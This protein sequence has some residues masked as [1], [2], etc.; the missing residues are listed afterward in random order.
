MS[1]SADA[2]PTLVTATT[3]MRQVAGLRN[4][5]VRRFGGVMA[6]P[7]TLVVTAEADPGFLASVR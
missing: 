4:V 7:Q 2:S 6:V 3:A 5:V 1:F